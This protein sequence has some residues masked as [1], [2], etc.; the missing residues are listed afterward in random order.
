MEWSDHDILAVDSDEEPNWKKSK[1]NPEPAEPVRAKAIGASC[2]TVAW[3]NAHTL[4]KLLETLSNG[5]GSNGS[6]E[7]HHNDSA[8]KHSALLM[9]LFLCCKE[10]QEIQHLQRQIETL[11]SEKF[12]LSMKV[13]C[14][15]MQLQFNMG[16]NMGFGDNNPWNVEQAN[17]KNWNM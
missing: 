16:G 17:H 12:D 9:N 13:A 7:H 14:L 2:S 3:T 11:T 5:L 6:N 8:L 4:H 10:N 1:S 15:E